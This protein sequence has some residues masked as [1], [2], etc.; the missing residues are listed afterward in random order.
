MTPSDVDLYMS[1]WIP[2][3]ITSGRLLRLL[4]SYIYISRHSPSRRDP[5]CQRAGSITA[6]IA[7]ACEVCG[8]SLLLD[9]EVRN[10]DEAN[11]AIAA[12]ADL[13]ILGNIEGNELAS[14]SS[15]CVSTGG[16]KE[17]GP[18]S[19]RAGSITESPVSEILRPPRTFVISR[20]RSIS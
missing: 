14:V 11:E 2:T 17:R 12:G 19:R 20:Q 4:T 7:Q 16:V 18:Y 6:A 10:E 5:R 9:V 8:F 1:S 13:I 3:I 15:V